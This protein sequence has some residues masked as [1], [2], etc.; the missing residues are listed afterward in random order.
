MR[1]LRR[2]FRHT[3]ITAS[4]T[5]ATT[6]AQHGTQHH[7]S[8]LRGLIRPRAVHLL[9]MHWPHPSPIQSAG[10]TVSTKG[11]GTDNR[12]SSDS[13]GTYARPPT[14]L[15]TPTYIMRDGATYEYGS[16]AAGATTIQRAISGREVSS[17]H[18]DPAGHYPGSECLTPPLPPWPTVARENYPLPDTTPMPPL[19]SSSPRN[20]MRT[21][22]TT[23]CSTARDRRTHSRSRTTC[24]HGR[25]GGAVTSATRGGASKI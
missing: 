20:S 1:F 21:I 7:C 11:S 18:G 5:A 3:R 13:L 10:S 23:H 17:P 4:T 25:R 8:S 16:A 2:S 9:G 24:V 22:P 6:P 14:P 12:D 19:S 15:N